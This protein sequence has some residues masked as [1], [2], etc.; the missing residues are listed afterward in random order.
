MAMA[1]SLN[2]F[3]NGTFPYYFKRGSQRLGA[4]SWILVIVFPTDYCIWNFHCVVFE[5]YQVKLHVQICELVH[6]PESSISAHF[7]EDIPESSRV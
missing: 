4:K 1:N 6:M 2:T 3:P 7:P 5:L